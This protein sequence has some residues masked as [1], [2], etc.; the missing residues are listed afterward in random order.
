MLNRIISIRKFQKCEV[1]QILL[2]KE[3]IN[4]LMALMKIVNEDY[5]Y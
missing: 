3:I 2:A 5:L 4:A 1:D